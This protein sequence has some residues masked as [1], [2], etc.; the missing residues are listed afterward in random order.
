MCQ[1][2]ITV[3]CE[4]LTNKIKRQNNASPLAI[5]FFLDKQ[6]DQV[7]DKPDKNDNKE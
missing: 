3:A 4:R 7:R 2:E 5:E 1:N 6:Q